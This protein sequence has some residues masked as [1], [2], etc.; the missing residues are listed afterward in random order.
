MKQRTIEEIET[1]AVAE[2]LDTPVAK[3]LLHMVATHAA[4]AMY[5]NLSREGYIRVPTEAKPKPD[6]EQMFDKN[7]EH[8][9]T[10]LASVGTVFAQLDDKNASLSPITALAAIIDNLGKG[11]K[12]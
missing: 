2:A 3:E 5:E 9:E 11:P 1:A 6:A 4:R 8:L 10:V 12:K 7:M